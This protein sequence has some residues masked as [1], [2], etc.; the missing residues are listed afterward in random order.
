MAKIV[1]P[2]SLVRNTEIVF[3]TALKTIQ[4]LVAG[5]LDDSSPGSQSGVTLQAVYSKC[6]ELWKSETD[7]NKLRFPLEAITEGKMDLINGWDWEDQQTKDLIRDGGWALKDAGGNSL[8]EYMSI[9]SLGGTFAATADQAY[10]QQVA[11]FDQSGTDFDKTDELNEPVKIFGA[12]GYG[13][14]DYTDFFKIF[15]REGGKL[16]DGGNLISDQNLAALDYTVFKLPLVNATDISIDATDATIDTTA[17]YLDSTLI[18]SGSDGDATADDPT[19]TSATGSFTSASVGQIIAIKSGSNIG[20]YQITTYVSATEVDVDRNFPATDAAMTWE[21]R[22]KGITFSYLKGSGFTTWANSTLYPA[23]AV[24]YDAAGNSGQGGWF[25]TPAGGTSSGTGVGDDVGVTDWEPYDGEEQIGVSYYAFNRI[26]DGNGAT[27]EQ[28]Y[29]FCQR[30][31]RA[32]GVGAAGQ[33]IDIND[34]A[35]ATPGQTDT[36][37]QNGNIANL[38]TLF[39]G[40]TLQTQPGVLIRNFD[41]NDT[42]RLEFFDITADEGGL[43]TEGVPLVSTKRTYPFVAAGTIVF[44]SELVDDT[45]A[46]WAMYFAN[47]DPPGDDTGADFDTTSAV[48]VKDNNG[49]DLKAETI[50]GN[51]S[52]DYD[53]DG[54]TQRGSA[55]AGT[56][57]PVIIVAIGLDGAQW[58]EAAF[59][60]TS[61][62]GLTFPVNAAKER[63]YSN[64]T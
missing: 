25:F 14:I 18:D 51:V 36:G 13:S 2:D 20:R 11:G 41:A 6:K 39:L 28:I 48:I 10:Y 44:N 64:P 31:L 56:D 40:T 4:L 57:V 35:N 49:D 3:D 5:N 43:D 63:N 1:D 52:F 33:P 22:D 21:L 47:D 34:E 38:L 46:E 59:T 24:V 19:F 23:A 16:F 32:T 45:D 29:E 37:A 62:V 58:I 50:T 7:L 53:Y 60:I 42:N 12:S 55:S 8:E 26:I 27:A 9:I 17:P 15:L 30:R 61:N 54:N